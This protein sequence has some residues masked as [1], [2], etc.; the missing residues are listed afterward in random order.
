MDPLIVES[1]DTSLMHYELCLKESKGW[2]PH[3]VLELSSNG[4]SRSRE[5]MLE[6]MP[7]LQM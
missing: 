6:A 1:L 4:S 3:V 5:G 7:H 2:H